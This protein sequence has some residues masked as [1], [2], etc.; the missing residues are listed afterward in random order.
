LASAGQRLAA[1]RSLKREVI[2][3]TTIMAGVLMGAAA[4]WWARSLEGQVQPVPGPGSG[5]V[6]VQGQ[7]DIGRLPTVDARQAGSW[8]VTLDQAADVRVTNAPT[9]AMAPLP[10]FKVG[11]RY[12]VTW[13]AGERETIAIAQLGT[14]GWIR[15]T[16]EGRQRWINLSGARAIE[17]LP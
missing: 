6:T 1:S 11:S 17:E 3:R 12:E 13:A 7:V 9:V 15:T 5:I 8:R 14:G 2:M 16:V 10:F 4:L